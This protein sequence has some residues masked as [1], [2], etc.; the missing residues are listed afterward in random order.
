MLRG[1]APEGEE[2]GARLCGISLLS[3]LPADPA[4]TLETRLALERS[5]LARGLV[6]RPGHG[7]VVTEE[8]VTVCEVP[9]TAEEASRHAFVP[10]T[11]LRE[12]LEA[13]AQ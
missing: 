12:D 7:L 5:A 1:W 2:E 9:L 8:L 4:A 10:L 13:E 11:R 6:V 3:A